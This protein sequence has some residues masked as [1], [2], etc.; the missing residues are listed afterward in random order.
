MIWSP[1]DVEQTQTIPL[2]AATYTLSIWDDR[3]PKSTPAGGRMSVNQGIVFALYRPQKY[4]DLSCEH[5]DDSLSLI[6]PSAGSE[7]TD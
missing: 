7:L 6:R 4:T 2:A 3:G 1:Y 5:T